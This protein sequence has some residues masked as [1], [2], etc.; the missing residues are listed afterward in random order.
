MNY[1]NEEFSREIALYW[2]H[3]LR[4]IAAVKD[5]NTEG[6][7]AFI[8]ASTVS[9]GTLV[10]VAHKPD[11]GEVRRFTLSGFFLEGQPYFTI[12]EDVSFINIGSLARWLDEWLIERGVPANSGYYPHIA[13]G[14]SALL[15][16]CRIKWDQLTVKIDSI[17]GNRTTIVATRPEDPERRVVTVTMNYDGTLNGRRFTIS[18]HIGQPLLVELQLASGPDFDECIIEYE[19]NMLA[20][21]TVAQWSG[22]LSRKVESRA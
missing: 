11:D 2:P 1:D 14:K 20:F 19:K 13:V 16:A 7:A 3:M 21:V 17:V 18:A 10:V 22:V 4:R 6:M 5:K 15:R 9:Q 12:D 8:S